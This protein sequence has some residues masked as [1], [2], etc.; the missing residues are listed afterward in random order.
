MSGRL[1]S[2]PSIRLPSKTKILVAIVGPTATGKSTLGIEIAER[3]GG[4]VISCDSTAVYRGF[5][6]GTDKVPLE[7]R[8]GIPHHLIDVVDPREN[9]SAAR[10]ATDAAAVIFETSARGRL[11]ILVG[12]TGL[13]YRA[14]TRGLFPGPGRDSDLRERFSALSDRYG[15]ER[16]H[17]LLHYIDPESADR[18]HA[19]D[20]KRLIRALEVY[21]LTGR[22]LTRHFEETRSLLA[23]YSIVG[24]ALRQSSETTAVKVAR[25]V[26]DQLNEGLVDEVRRLRDAGIPDSAAPFGGMVYRQVLA[27][28]NGVGTEESTQDDIIR[29]N[30]RYARRQLIWFRK[31]PN[32]HWIQ[33]DDG[34]VYACRVA[35]QIVREHVVT[36]S[37]SVVL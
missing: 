25:R 5:D 35:E 12:G 21:Y 26:E 28:L 9:Y 13:Y 11:P 34:P 27:F 33:V 23:G 30:R 1:A 7:D 10:Y 2:G 6:I 3:F 24:I 16:L 18:I 15:V 32:L 20:V 22:P 17:R 19:R 31:E 14:L 29:A 4:E 37:E 8:R 36:R